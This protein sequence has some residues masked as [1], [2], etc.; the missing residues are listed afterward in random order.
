M[1]DQSFLGIRKG[2]MR[3]ATL[4]P[5]AEFENDIGGS[6]NSFKG[7]KKNDETIV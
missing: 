4:N 2:E 6:C 3:K 5:E 1:K 7:Y